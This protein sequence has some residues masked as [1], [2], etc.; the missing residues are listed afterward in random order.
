V[1][2]LL[3]KRI[4]ELFEAA[5]ELDGQERLDYL[6]GQCGADRNLLDNVLSLLHADEKRPAAELPSTVTTLSIPDVVA[7]CMT[8]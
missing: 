5:R 2:A 4:G 3:W 6:R 7:D 8:W 1:N